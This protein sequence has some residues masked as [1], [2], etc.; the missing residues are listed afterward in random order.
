MGQAIVVNPYQ[1]ML[2]LSIR[3]TAT[4]QGLSK[5]DENSLFCR[6]GIRVRVVG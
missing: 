3:S 6:S 5:P 2:Y 4:Y 1:K